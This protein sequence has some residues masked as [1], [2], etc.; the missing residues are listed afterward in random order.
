MSIKQLSDEQIQSMSLEEKDRWWLENCYKGNMPQ[1]TLRSALTGMLIGGILSVTNL[2]VGVKTGWT[3]GVGITSVVLAFA[4]FKILSKFGV[5]SEISILENNAMQS[6]ATSA[7]YMTAPLVSSMAAYMVITGTMIPQYQ[8]MVWISLLSLLGVFFAFPLKKRFINDEQLPFPEGRAAG[9]VM[10]N[11]HADDGG[12]DGMLKAKILVVG[13]ALSAMIEFLRSEKLLDHLKMAKFRLP[14]YWDNFLYV[15]DNSSRNPFRGIVPKIMG[16][17]IKDLSV[18][19]DSSIVMMATGGL[20]G[21]KVG[22][23]L[24]I[25]ALFN[26]CFL[27]PWAISQGIIAKVGWKDI[28]MWLLWGGVAMMTTSSLYSFFAKP[29]FILAAF[30]RRKGKKRKDILADI[31]L[32]LWVSAVGIPATGILL[33]WLG[34]VWFNIEWWVTVV[35]IPLVFVFTLIAVTSTGLTAITPGGA[36]GK[37]T[38]LTFAILKP[39]DMGTNIMTAGIN[40]EVALNA[41]NL[42]MDIKPGYMLGGKPRH[43]AIGH[44][45]GIIAGALVSVPVFYILIQNDVSNITSESLPMPGAQIWI[46][47]AKVLA[48]GL[49]VLPQSTRVA[50]F[51]GGLAGILIEFF[52]RRARGKFPISA[53]GLG[54]SFVLKFSDCWA[55]A[56]GS[57]LFWALGK[58]LKGK[59]SVSSKIFVDN[60]ETTCAG[61]IAG[62]SIM[63]IILIIIEQIVLK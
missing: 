35:A 1:L 3:L 20:M 16:T 22:C 58:G 10:D 30:K 57:L 40:G 9:V 14:E 42:L 15:V 50:V 2:Y 29:E 23:S 44:C 51:L 4:F 63:G 19:W 60:Q 61:V 53:M 8:T 28:N 48:S 26:Y 24:L 55:M 32:P 37:L 7:G 31:E 52:N 45:L 12:K 18:R 5:G 43:Q 49:K 39:G 62:G 47:V 38:Q 13:A 27:V 25:G 59:S 33:L 56:V 36:L 11:L 17:P 6:I 46:A 34:K 41:S 54:L 21:T